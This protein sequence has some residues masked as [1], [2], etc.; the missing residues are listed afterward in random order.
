[1]CMLV[2]VLYHC[3]SSDEQNH[4]VIASVKLPNDDAQV[5]A[6]R[7]DNDRGGSL[8]SLDTP[9]SLLQVSLSLSLSPSLSIL[10]LSLPPPLSFPIEYGGFGSV[11]GKIETDIKINH[12]GEV[13]RCCLSQFHTH[14]YHHLH[15]IWS[16]LLPQ[17]S[18]HA[19]KS[20]HHCHQDS[21][22]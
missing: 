8:L 10:S 9:L 11:C 6:S 18:L 4:L 17:G 2:V 7:Y 14:P 19:S 1:M 20:L 13:N 16:L 5:D 3:R 15:H 12:E 22:L 21:L